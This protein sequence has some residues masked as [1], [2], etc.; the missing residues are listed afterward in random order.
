M[1]ACMHACMHRFHI[2]HTL[3]TLHALHTYIR[4]YIHKYIHTCMHANIH[5]YTHKYIHTYIHTSPLPLRRRCAA[6]AAVAT[7]AAAVEVVHLDRNGHRVVF[8][9]C[10]LYPVLCSLPPIPCPLSPV[11]CPSPSPSLSPKCCLPLFCG[12]PGAGRPCRQSS[13]WEAIW[14]RKYRDN[15]SAGRWRRR[16]MKGAMTKVR[17]VCTDLTSCE[18]W[19]VGATLLWAPGGRTPP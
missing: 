10:P 6:A 15:G 3:H 12:R 4:T 8:T 2:L 11:P 7:A 14:T 5:T 13:F 1:H 16:K 17:P 19:A 18:L 9:R